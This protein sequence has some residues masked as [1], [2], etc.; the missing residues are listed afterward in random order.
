M[1]EAIRRIESDGPL[2]DQSVLRQ[3]AQTPE[4]APWPSVRR[5]RLL[6]ERL[7]LP[8]RVAR[9]RDLAPLVLIGLAALMV[10]A[11]L[12]LAGAVVDAQERRINVIASLAG[13]LG[14]HGLSLLV[15]VGALL[16][17]GHGRAGALAGRLWL[18]LT[19][20]TALGRGREGAALLQAGAQLLERARLLPWLLGLASHLLWTLSFC[21]AV[22]ALL[23]ALA[24]RRYTLGWE[25]TLL[26]PAQFAR[27]IDAL[28]WLPGRLGFPVPDA[29]LVRAA[30]DP[31][32]T[33]GPAGQAVLAWWLVGCVLVY[34]LLPRLL[35]ATACVAVWALRRHRLQPDFALPYYRQL[36]ARLDALAPARVVDAEHAQGQAGSLPQPASDAH[37]APVLL[38]FE[39]PPERPWPPVDVPAGIR[40]WACDGS[41]AGRDAAVRQV[42]AWRPGRLVVACQAAA[43]PDRGTERLLRELLPLAGAL[44]LG[45]VDADQA[46]DAER[47]RWPRWLQ[48]AGLA[49]TVSFHGQ[50]Q[51]GFATPSAEV[52][53]TT[54]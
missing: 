49:A 28:A 42:A 14:L 3:L 23:A 26:D 1:T 19:A 8:A 17:P 27:A 44:H 2:E 39:L 16:L 40:T 47:A 46:S 24:L 35:C 11:G 22:A 30:G 13:L 37:G 41:A 10:L 36:Q 53:E 9:A 5:A 6:A 43:S 25:T 54:P 45:L 4:P 12:G 7:G 50:W 51:A 15:W 32:S 20:R 29:A 33:P 52:Q 18:T 34:G 38:A 48:D 31:A 21:V